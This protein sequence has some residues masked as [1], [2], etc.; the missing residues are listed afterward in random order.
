[1]IWPP[2]RWMGSPAMVA[3]RSLNFT[4]RIAAKVTPSS[5]TL[6]TSCAAYAII[7]IFFK[8]P[9]LPPPFPPSLISCTVSVDGK[10]HVYLLTSEWPWTGKCITSFFFFH[11]KLQPKNSNTWQFTSTDPKH[12]NVLVIISIHLHSLTFMSERSLLCSSYRTDSEY[13]LHAAHTAT[14]PTN[15]S[16]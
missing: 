6:A 1:M 9:L 11:L 2:P 4:L 10:H 5:W 7:Y 8:S 16:H 14:V 15:G 3:S 13:R 12:C